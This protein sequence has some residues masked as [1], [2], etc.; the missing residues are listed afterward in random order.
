MIT[1][2][3]DYPNMQNMCISPTVHTG[4]NVAL[5]TDKECDALSYNSHA[6]SN[7][8]Y[9]TSSERIFAAYVAE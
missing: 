2:L 9:S 6:Q 4:R 5:F 8:S 7:P 3:F 1:S